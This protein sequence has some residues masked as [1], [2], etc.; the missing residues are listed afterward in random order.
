MLMAKVV[1]NFCLLAAFAEL[2]D[3][4]PFSHLHALMLKAKK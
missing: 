1:R 2:L 3:E 4:Q